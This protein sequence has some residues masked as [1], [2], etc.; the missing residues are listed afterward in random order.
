VSAS[1]YAIEF[2]CDYPACQSVGTG[3]DYDKPPPGWI[4]LDFKEIQILNPFGS[5]L[6]DFCSLHHDVSVARLAAL[7]HTIREEG[8]PR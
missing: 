3:T 2:R 7:L 6:T 8:M 5:A 4:R 1:R